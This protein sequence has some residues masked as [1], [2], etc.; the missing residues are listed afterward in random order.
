MPEATQPKE[1]KEFD[2]LPMLMR[3][4]RVEIKRR[5][6]KTST[7]RVAVDGGTID[8]NTDPT[9]GQ[10]EV[11]QG[12]TEEDEDD[13]GD[14][15]EELYD[16]SL[17]SEEPIDR[18][19]G[20]EILSHDSSAVNLDRAK[21][22]LPLLSNHND[23]QLPIGRLRNVR[24]QGGKLKARLK[25]SKTQPG[26]DAKTLVDE[27]HR[28]M[29]IGYSI[30]E[31]EVTPGK[32]DEPS[33][34]RA[35]KWTPLEGSLVSVPADHTIGVGR[36]LRNG[37]TFPVHVRSVSN[38][39]PTGSTENRMPDPVVQAGADPKDSAEIVRRAALHGVSEHVA[40]WFERG[41]TLHQVNEEILKLR[42]TS[43]TKQP[44]AEQ[45]DLSDKEAR[46]YS[47]ARAIVA[48]AD[49]ASGVRGVNCF[50]LE[51]SNE[52]ERLMPQVYRRRGGLFV[53]TSLR[54]SKFQVDPARRGTALTD[55]QVR[56]LEGALLRAQSGVIDSQTVNQI[57]EVVF[58]VYGGELI[59][60]L[61]NQALVVQMGA[62]V[63]TGLDSPIAF[64]RQ[65]GDVTAYWVAEDSGADVTAS[66]VSTDL[67]TLTPRTLMAATAY[68]RQL[69]VQSSIDVEAMVRTSIAAKHALAW[70]LAALHGTGSNNQP[71][72]VYN[73]PNVLTVDFSSGAFSNTGQT[74]AFT[75]VVQMEAQVATANAL[76]GNLGFLTT[77]GIAA[78]SKQTLKFPNAAIAQGGVLWEGS[79]LE[80]TMD[81]YKA[82]ATN[83]V[84]KTL[85]TNGVASPAG[86][87][88][89]L[90][91]GNWTDLL[92][93]QW[94]GAMEMIVDPYSKKKQGLIEIASFQMADVEIRHPVSFCIAINLNK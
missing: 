39:P 40:E 90:V 84:S 19:W 75:G 10:A 21:D 52:L 77:P 14:G 11:G 23:Y 34:Y 53:P 81:G 86:N 70:D 64:P 69:L 62:R 93:G 17:S 27:G 63:L 74:V 44:A 45:L 26:R 3:A 6:K 47:Y 54:G 65:T 5:A 7:T 88:H 46:Q 79:I 35:T 48:A 42:A 68:S 41:L 72:G 37:K 29:S 25:F 4:V 33:V 91:F 60:I 28:E 38:L 59:E 89:G 87:F 85:G 49:A 30:D 73:A 18:W 12:G 94:G 31:Y 20:R 55:E 78:D 56:S 76:L 80:G 61:R 67:V 24:T 22:G 1:L 2:A 32:A 16:V 71:V 9:R 50:E 58:T 57:K 66:T 51:V 83:Q 36:S 82:R 15:D 92:I 13:E 8:I 43:P